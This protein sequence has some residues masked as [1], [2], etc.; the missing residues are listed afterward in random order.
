MPLHKSSSSRSLSQ[1][2]RL[3]ATPEPVPKTPER[4]PR[5]TNVPMYVQSANKLA[6]FVVKSQHGDCSREIARMTMSIARVRSV[7][8]VYL[9]WPLL[10]EIF[11]R[12]VVVVVC[13][14]VLAAVLNPSDLS[15]AHWISTSVRT[16][17]A[18]SS[19]FK[20]LVHTVLPVDE[21]SW[22]WRRY[23][24]VFC[25]VV[26]VESIERDAVGVFGL[27]FWADSSY[28]LAS[29]CRTYLPWIAAVTN[30]GQPSGVQSHGVADTPASEH[31]SRSKAVELRKTNQFAAAYEKYEEAAQLC[32]NPLDQALYRLE[33]VRCLAKTLS[34]NKRNA[35]TTCLKI[36]RLCRQSCQ[37]LVGHGEFH[38]AGT[39]LVE[40]AA[41]LSEWSLP[42]ASPADTS[43]VLEHI[44]NLYAEALLV[45][46]AAD[47]MVDRRLAFQA[48]MAGGSLY[49]ARA[50]L[51]C[52]ADSK[53]AWLGAAEVAFRRLGTSHVDINV[54]WAKEAFAAATWTHLARQDIVGAQAA[55]REFDDLCMAHITATDYLFQAVFD[56]Y[57]K[58]NVDLVRAGK[59]AFDASGDTLL[60]W[61]V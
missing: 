16:T 42:A 41:L 10:H 27:W 26:H 3:P 37:E 19:W 17:A 34:K 33:G 40:V 46:Q 50:L 1:L 6:P 21:A 51:D 20:A 45:L 18:P 8:C 15:F 9:F 59:V 49:A 32:I 29:L 55:Y 13:I 14:L 48:G 4:P 43:D 11:A 2:A 30:G 5:H 12:L 57:E 58:W 56:A 44:A 31:A 47:T 53:A 23:N 36:E 60:G 35:A 52:P 39:A 38:T 28:A 7:L 54:S 61:Q 25:T 22:T 24:L